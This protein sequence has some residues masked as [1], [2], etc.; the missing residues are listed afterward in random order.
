MQKR[1]WVIVDGLTR[2]CTVYRHMFNSSHSKFILLKSIEI[3]YPKTKKSCSE[4]HNQLMFA[5]SCD[6]IERENLLRVSESKCISPQTTQYQD[7]TFLH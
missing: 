4:I 7:T 2:I 3:I 5:L 1:I 6:L